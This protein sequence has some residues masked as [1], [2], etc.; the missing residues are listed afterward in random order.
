MTFTPFRSNYPQFV[1]HQV[2]VL[3]TPQRIGALT[4]VHGEGVVIAYVDSGFSR[5]PDIEGRVIVH[6]DASTHH[7]VE[8]PH[9]AQTSPLSWHGQMTSVIGSGDGRSS[10][11]RFT[12]AAPRSKLVLVK[13]STPDGRIKEPDILRGLRWIYDTRH[14]YGVR[15]VNV[16]VGGDYV[17]DDPNHPLYAVVRR[18]HAAGIV[19][20]VSAGNANAEYMVP[21]ASAPHALTVGGYDDQNTTDERQWKLFHHNFARTHEWK[22]KPEVLASAAWIASPL[23]PDSD[24]AREVMLL[25][26]LLD[27]RSAADV[28]EVLKHGWHTLG[29]THDEAHTLTD[30]VITRLQARIYEHKVINE[31]YQHVDGTSVAAPIVSS[32][33]AQMLEVNPA[34]T[35]DDVK[36]ILTATAQPLPDV[37]PHKQG[38]GRIQP[39]AAVTMARHFTASLPHPQEHTA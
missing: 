25:G 12:S 21:P 19:V 28:L 15:I 10:G 24:T 5:H 33:I 17:S 8:T 30:E 7:V 13:V 39:A 9:V 3:P 20:V 35:P 22:E 23:L 36:H 37:P 2:T 32:V 34:L 14:R 1:P 4:D 38:A 31:H 16:S 29:L 26:R 11:G 27:A 18:L 6:A